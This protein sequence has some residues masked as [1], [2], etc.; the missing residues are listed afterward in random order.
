[1]VLATAAASAARDRWGEGAVDVLV[2]E[3]WAGLWTG[4][5]AVRRVWAWPKD[6]R[7]PAGVRS[8]AARL[9]GEGYLEAFDLQSSP[10][11]RALT[12]LAG[13]PRVHRP[14]RH[15]LARRLLVLTR[16]L[17]PPS[18][19]RVARAF[20]QAVVPGSLALPALYPGPALREEAAARL[21]D[22]GAVGLVPGARH[23]TKRWPLERYVEVGRRLARAGGGPVPV[24]FGPDEAW[25]LQA[26]REAWPEGGEWAAI[27]EAD[28]A[29]LA[30]LL[31][32]VSGLVTGDSGLMHVAA[33]MGTPVVAIFGPTVRS[34]GFEPA[35]PG[36]RVLEV[37]GLEC[38]PC[39]LH[40]GARCP[41]GHFRCMLEI[42][43][44][45]VFEAAISISGR[46]RATRPVSP[47]TR[48]GE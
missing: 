26:W 38:R 2:K 37:E 1:V 43:V 27:R 15:N 31:G 16:R 46:G 36:H 5:P 7:G 45:R 18:D 35:G 8:W 44:D 13:I 28:L 9:R 34:F 42:G 22:D 17:G 39:S 32:R 23:A 10:R 24:F 21:P 30:A 25:L 14:E 20:A 19:Y 12:A 4:N 40:G 47:G 3:E 33:A 6:V 41:R 48:I 29:R 11:T